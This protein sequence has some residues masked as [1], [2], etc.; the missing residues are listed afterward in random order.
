[1]LFSWVQFLKEDAL[2]L[3]HIDS[4]LE[5][6]SVEHNIPYNSR[7]TRDSPPLT[8][9][10]TADQRSPA[11]DCGDADSQGAVAMDSCNG[12]QS[13]VK[14]E[15]ADCTKSPSDKPRSGPS[16]T[17]AQALLSQLLVYDAAERRK[18]FAGTFFDCGV[19]FTGWL[20][21]E[22]VQLHECG[23][24]FC[25][26]CLAEIYKLQITEGNVRGVTCPQADCIASPTPAQVQ[27]ELQTL[28]KLQIHP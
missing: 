15:A 2:R 27:K 13:P 6:P 11:A 9:A 19:C 20:G 16:L 28:C 4:L 10:C 1:M 26:A 23:H 14:E 17:P 8:A 25:Q 18:V 7:D 3:L 5:L 22:C 21:S 12:G 24:V